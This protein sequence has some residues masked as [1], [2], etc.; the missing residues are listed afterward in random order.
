MAFANFIPEIWD[1]NL[2][3]NF[4]EQVIAAS[5]ANRQYEGTLA[6]GNTV[7]ITTAVDVGIKD[8]KAAG[9]QTSP[10]HVDTTQLDLVID[11]EKSF[12]FLIDDIDRVQ[13]AG[14][15]SA[16]T[17]SASIGMAE[18]SDRFL[19]AQWVG[20][21][22]AVDTGE[23]SI[24][25]GD[26]AY[27]IVRDL[28]KTLNKAHV[29]QD[30]RYLLC[31]AEFEGWLLDAS[32][33]LVPVN[34]SGSPAALRDATIGR[35]LNFTTVVTENLPTVDFPQALAVYAPAVAYVSQIMETEAMRDVNSFSDRIRGLHVYGA[36][37]IRPV[38]LAVYTASA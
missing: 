17:Q 38:G 33:K 30:S 29:P 11:Q 34:T 20:A 16:F 6:S 7:H 27:D 13:A 1:A 10:D 12:D 28:R 23:A 37:V 32:S 2:L 36:K 18:D 14:N 4:H 19:L 8:Y 9:R 5:I 3:L 25:S 22:V 31:N 35:L 21:A 24:T 26:A 15:M